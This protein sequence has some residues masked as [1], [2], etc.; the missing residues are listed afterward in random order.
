MRYKQ[1]ILIICLL[2][3]SNQLAY[4]SGFYLHDNKQYWWYHSEDPYFYAVVP[5]NAERYTKKTLFGNEILE[6]AFDDG[7]TIME[8]GSFKG[9]EVSEVVDFVGKKW[10]SMIDNLVVIANRE[11]TTSNDLK[12]FFYA[13]EGIGADGK[14]GMLRSVYFKKGDVVVYQAMFLESSK[15]KGDLQ[16][17]WLRAVNEFEW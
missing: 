7:S 10:T 2:L 3:L 16:N 12:T 4:A 1:I 5:S 14:K 17:H 15:Y 13:I 9:K 6:I 11:I 8:I